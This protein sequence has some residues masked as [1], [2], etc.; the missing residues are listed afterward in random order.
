MHIP[1]GDAVSYNEEH[2]D[3]RHQNFKGQCS[4]PP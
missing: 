4:L 1:Q 3:R 2:D